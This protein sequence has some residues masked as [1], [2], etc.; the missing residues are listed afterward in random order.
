MQASPTSLYID[1]VLPASHT[2]SSAYS[3]VDKTP[4]ADIINLNQSESESD[5]HLTRCS[6]LCFALPEHIVIGLIH[7]AAYSSNWPLWQ[8]VKV[9]INSVEKM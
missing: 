8:L 2:V 5:H 3:S 9:H 1:F 4:A 7:S 6:D